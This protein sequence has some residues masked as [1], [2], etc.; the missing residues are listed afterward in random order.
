MPT[1]GGGSF[2]V[3]IEVRFCCT[4]LSGV[5]AFHGSQTNPKLSSLTG[6]I[7]ATYRS[8]TL[9]GS[10]ELTIDCTRHN[11]NLI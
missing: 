8:V 3:V 10:R 11:V 5:I 6:F 1:L 7:G 2:D 4:R 9:Q